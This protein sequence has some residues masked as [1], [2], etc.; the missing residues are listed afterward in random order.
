MVSL[1]FN[2]VGTPSQPI[3][4]TGR[5]DLAGTA[6]AETTNRLWGGVIVLGRAPIRGGALFA[7]ETSAVPVGHITSGGFGPSVGAPV[8]MGYVSRPFAED[9][10]ALDLM[11]RGKAVPARVAPMPFTP[12]RYAR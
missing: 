1:K 8:A 7:D 3:V 4:F 6:N 10:S 11:V 5:E 9:G 2:A 12:H